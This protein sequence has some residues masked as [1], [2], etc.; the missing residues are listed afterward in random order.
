MEIEFSIYE[1]KDESYYTFRR[2][3][4]GAALLQSFLYEY[5]SILVEATRIG[6]GAISIKL[7]SKSAGADMIT[8]NVINSLVLR[9]LDLRDSKRP[10]GWPEYNEAAIDIK[11]RVKIL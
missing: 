5:S 2:T 11:K 1:I 3:F 9:I 4:S 6:G 7:L 8:N 10:F